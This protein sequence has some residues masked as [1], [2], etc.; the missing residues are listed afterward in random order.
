MYIPLYLRLQLPRQCYNKRMQEWYRGM[1]RWGAELLV[2]QPTQAR[3]QDYES[4]LS[5]CD[6]PTLATRRKYLGLC[7]MYKIINGHIFF[8]PQVFAPR[9]TPLR[10]AQ[11][12]LFCQ[13]LDRGA[14]SSRTFLLFVCSEMNSGAF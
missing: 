10:P 11:Q 14:S 13:P 7:T 12:M 1:R 9:V 3:G 4:L 5:I 2:A 8:P 6:L